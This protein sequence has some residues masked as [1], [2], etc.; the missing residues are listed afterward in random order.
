MKK[1]LLFVV[2]FFYVFSVTA[3]IQPYDLLKKVISAFDESKTYEYNIVLKERQWDGSYRSSKSYNRIN[4]KPLAVY[5]RILEGKNNGVEVLY[6]PSLYGDRIQLNA[7]RFLPNFKINPQSSML[8]KGQHHT[9]REAGYEYL[10]SFLRF[11]F[12]KYQFKVN[13]FCSV[14]A[15]V[16][17][18]G[19]NMTQLTINYPEFKL[20]SYTLKEGE[21]T[22]TIAQRLHVSEFLII[23]K[24]ASLEDYTDAKPGDVIMI[25]T[26]YA[27]KTIMLFDEN[28]TPIVAEMYD[29]KSLFER[30]VFENVKINPSLPANAFSKDCSDYGF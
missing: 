24:N 25:P 14:K 20:E 29:D 4:N 8:R 28:Y 2:A 5:L 18:N 12:N 3:Q 17:F 16:P 11:V 22:Y 9:L 10:I 21:T 23:D 7:G 15:N 30:Y 6:N 1:A 19:K 26:A 13:D 27:K